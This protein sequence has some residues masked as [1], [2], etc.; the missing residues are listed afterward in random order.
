[1][2]SHST[3]GST[4]F[5]GPAHA[6]SGRKMAPGRARAQRPNR[7][8]KHKK[9]LDPV[10]AV[11]TIREAAKVVSADARDRLASRDWKP[12]CGMRD[13]LIHDYIG[14]DLD[15]VAEPPEAPAL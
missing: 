1:M 3:K 9:R 10:P 7:K 12:I 5:L 8:R 6:I 15:A 11:G 4:T 13:L 14:V 2:T